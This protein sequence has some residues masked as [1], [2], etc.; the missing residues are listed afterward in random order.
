MPLSTQFYTQHETL[1]SMHDVYLSTQQAWPNWMP[2]MAYTSQDRAPL[3]DV[4]VCIFLR[5]GADGLNIVVPHGD[6]DYYAARPKIALARPDQ[7]SVTAQARA[8]DLDGFFGLHPSLS[9][10]L[11][12]FQQHQMVAVHA[13]GSPDPTRSH[14]DAMDYME[15]GIAGN[16][17]LNTGWIGRHLSSQEAGNQSVLRAVG[18]GDTLQSSLRGSI[19]TL[20]L[21]SISS[22]HLQG[23]TDSTDTTNLL[24]AIT[25]LY[26]VDPTALQTFAQQTQTIMDLISK[27]NIASYTASKG[28]QYNLNDDFEMALMQTAALIKADVGLEVSAIDLGGWDTH[29]NQLVSQANALAQLGQ[30]LANFATDLDDKL[31]KVTVVVMSEFGRRVSENASAGTDHGHGNMMLLMGGHMA[32]KPVIA[33]WPGLSQDKLADGDLS[34]TIDYRDVLGEILS[35]RLQNP[36]LDVVFPNFTP[37]DYE[38]TVRD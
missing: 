30:G 24:Q 4:L 11:P 28:V 14:F 8:L 16:T 18:W 20:A 33:N 27:I 15:R 31:N 22:Y 6:N 12:F 19:N 29:Q 23:R 2:R 10:V 17:T 5:G 1:K 34:I 35:K 3:G 21:R 13:T 25:S 32:S 38:I 37:H 9:P 36:H 7:K 26:A